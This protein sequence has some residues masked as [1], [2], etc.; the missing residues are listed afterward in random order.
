MQIQ[1]QQQIIVESQ[2]VLQ[3]MLYDRFGDD[4]KI[5]TYHKASYY[6]N[7]YLLGIH[8][9]YK[10]HIIYTVYQES[11]KVSIKKIFDQAFR[12]VINTSDEQFQ[13][14]FYNCKKSAYIKS[15][16]VDVKNV[17]LG[18]NV[19]Y[20]L[21]ASLDEYKKA[22]SL[23]KNIIAK[24]YS[25]S[26]YLNHDGDVYT[27]TSDKQYDVYIKTADLEAYFAKDD[28]LS[29]CKGFEDAARTNT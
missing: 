15:S 28:L 7:Q 11:E 17:D 24:M 12:F 23:R 21:V 6:Y 1:K 18:E 26:E 10:N 27:Q 29:Y 22:E 4:A 16:T 3:Q 5:I 20:T 14:L 9:N 19:K 8:I 13:Q 2:R 25:L